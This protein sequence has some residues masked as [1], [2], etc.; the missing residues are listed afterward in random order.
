MQVKGV[1]DRMKQFQPSDLE[2]GYQGL[3]RDKSPALEAWQGWRKRTVRML[4][5]P[6]PLPQKESLSIQAVSVS[7]YS[8]ARYLWAHS[9]FFLAMN[10]L[11]AWHDYGAWT[12]EI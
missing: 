9:T 1:N 5:R 10:V 3:R 2:Q 6:K 12:F 11:S 4:P 7:R 8:V